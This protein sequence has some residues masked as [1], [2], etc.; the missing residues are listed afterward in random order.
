MLCSCVFCFTKLVC[1]LQESTPEES[2]IPTERSA[3]R[4]VHE[5]SKR[6]SMTMTVCISDLKH[7]CITWS[8]TSTSKLWRG[9]PDYDWLITTVLSRREQSYRHQPIPL[10]WGGA[11][12]FIRLQ[13]FSWWVDAPVLV[14]GLLRKIHTLRAFIF[15]DFLAKLVRYATHTCTIETSRTNIIIASGQLWISVCF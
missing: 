7:M 4:L 6:H 10:A 3:V 8:S 2:D 15:Q 1:F 13:R 14:Q 12:M 9:N 11:L 5:H